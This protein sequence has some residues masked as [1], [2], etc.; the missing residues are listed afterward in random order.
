M[1]SVYGSSKGHARTN[2]AAKSCISA[3]VLMINNFVKVKA[4]SGMRVNHRHSMS[5]EGRAAYHVVGE[6]SVIGFICAVNADRFYDI[7]MGVRLRYIS[8]APADIF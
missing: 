6:I 2:S 4:M 1:Q 8:C 3:A 5:Q 7:Q